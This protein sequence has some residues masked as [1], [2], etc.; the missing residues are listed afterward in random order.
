LA[1]IT[2]SP[3]SSSRTVS[4]RIVKDLTIGIQLGESPR[5]FDAQPHDAAEMGRK[6]GK[7]IQV[8]LREIG[9]VLAVYLED[10]GG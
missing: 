4:L 1:W 9:A 5:S 8:L 3:L 6:A 2:R 10:T 7:E